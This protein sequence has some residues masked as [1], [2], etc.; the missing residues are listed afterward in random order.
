MEDA[1]KKLNIVS[2]IFENKII[3]LRNNIDRCKGYYDSDPINTI[4]S[5][6][7]KIFDPTNMDDRDTIDQAA[8]NLEIQNKNAERNSC[9]LIY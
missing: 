6:S 2:L 3:N 9:P 1:F 4:L 7:E 8:R 5:E